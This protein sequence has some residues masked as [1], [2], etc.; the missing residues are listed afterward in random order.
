MLSVRTATAR[1]SSSVGPPFP[2]QEERMS[3]GKQEQ[4]SDETYL[5]G[6]FHK[7]YRR[8]F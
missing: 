5:L 6:N 3:A 7:M 2:S 1:T 4:C 8:A